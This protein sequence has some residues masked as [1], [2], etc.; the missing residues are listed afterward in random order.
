MLFEIEAR[1]LLEI[2]VGQLIQIGTGQLF[3]M[4]G[5]LLLCYVMYEMVA[6]RLFDM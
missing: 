6:A 1:Q 4:V 3:E 2:E 5:V